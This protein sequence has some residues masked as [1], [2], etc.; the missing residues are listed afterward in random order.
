M[1]TFTFD[2]QVRWSC[3][4]MVSELRPGILLGLILPF[5]SFLHV[6]E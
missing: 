2:L 5:A 1:Y 4:L 3:G 6:E